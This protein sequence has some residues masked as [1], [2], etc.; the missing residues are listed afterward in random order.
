PAHEALAAAAPI[1]VAQE[2]A[3]VAELLQLDAQLVARRVGLAEPFREAA[4]LALPAL[5]LRL[6]E[7][8]RGLEPAQRVVSRRVLLPRACADPAAELEHQPRIAARADAR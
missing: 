5:E 4:D 1:Q 2:L 3:R 6:R 7:A 8:A